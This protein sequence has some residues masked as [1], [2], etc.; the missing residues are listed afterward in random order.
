MTSLF[1]GLLLADYHQLYL[2]DGALPPLPD[3]FGS[4]T[5]ARR[6][7]AGPEALVSNGGAR[8]LCV[9]RRLSSQRR[10]VDPVFG[11]LSASAG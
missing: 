5:I 1:D 11:R 10:Q 2:C 9:P 3:D 6:V 8:P 7:A 4:Q